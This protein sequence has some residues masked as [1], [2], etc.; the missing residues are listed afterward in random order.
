MRGEE[1]RGD[2]AQGGLFGDGLGAVLAELGGVPLVAGSGQ[3]QP[4]QSK[5]SFWLTLQQ[6]QGGAAH[7]HLLLGDA[8]GVG[9]AG[10]PAAE[11]WGS[12]TWGAS[13]TGSDAGGLPAMALSLEP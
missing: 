5:P 8:Q 1:V 3:A 2:A 12:P 7:A 10:R 9:E 4:G 13:W 11:C 6:G